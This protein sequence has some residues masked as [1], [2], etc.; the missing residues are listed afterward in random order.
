MN[1]PLKYVLLSVAGLLLLVVAGLAYIAITFDP[2]HYKTQIV[3][4]V[5]E[6]QQRI[7]RLD[8]DI[9]LIFFP[10]IGIEL[11][12]LSLSEF[13][14]D[15]PFAALNSARASLALLPLFSKR[16]VVD[17]VEIDGLQAEL[18]KFKNGTSNID[19][20]IG[21][22]SEEKKN[23]PQTAPIKFDIAA[24]NI[25]N[26]S[27]NYRN[28]ASG[29][30]YAL[31]DFNLRSGRIASGVPVKIDLVTRI[32]ANQPKLDINTQIKTIF[33][34]DLESQQ[35]AVE[36]LDMQ[37][38]GAA[39]DI[40]DLALQASG[41]AAAKL[42]TQEYAANKFNVTATGSK[43]KDRFDIK[44]TAPTLNLGKDKFNGEK[45]VFSAKLDGEVG[46]VLASLNIPGVEGNAR[47]F[48]TGVL[49]LDMDVKQPEQAFKI[50]LSTPLFG[51]FEVPQFN[52][53]DIV[54]AVH[55][56]GD[57]LPN[58][59]VK[60]EMRGS[61][62]VDMERESMQLTLAGG[63][64]Q[65]QVK[66]KLGVNNFSK[67]MTRFDVDVDQLD[68]DLYLPKRPA[69]AVSAKPATAG[70]E[71][72]LD[73]SALKKLNLEGSL[74]IGSLK[75]ANVKVSQLR[76]DMKAQ[77][78]LLN[79]SPLSAKLYQ[80]SLNGS[81]T[82]NAAHSIP[83]FTI[84]QNLSGID[85]GPLLKDAANIDMLQGKGNVTLNLTTQGNLVG[86]LKKGLNGGMSLSLSDGAVKGINIAKKLR[87]FGKG[88][89][90]QAADNSEKTDFSEMK[91][92]FKVN[93]G[94]AHNDD[95]LLKSPLIRLGGVGDINIGN[96]SINYLAK[97]TL[98][99]TLEGQG[100]KDMVG[101]ITVPVR[102]SG[103][104]T[105]LKYTIEFGALVSEVAKQKVEAKKEE[106]KKEEVKSKLQ[107]Q[108]KSGLKDLFK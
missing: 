23:E 11:E 65:S 61:A 47:S 37:V 42:G 43:G 62:Q 87:E 82:V 88:T 98:A 100:G 92:S 53:S 16:L 9:K 55:A 75:A 94:V 52:L 59:S 85:V 40:T 67:P 93:N 99:K 19:D 89:Q 41:D 72:P 76:A 71:Q 21:K 3:E 101:G 27:L 102:L 36:G 25:T 5:K 104:Y 81:L 86:G 84:N 49:I 68:A 13:Q 66:A 70:P 83:T 77:N 57:K 91:A 69:G 73:L 63:L 14:S 33:T 60:S 28:E 12:K 31:K 96:D 2:N 34:F 1:K 4:A 39:L 64:L 107:E 30:H 90:T 10:S 95:L 48:K 17:A 45:L 26:S 20:L 7:L 44:F 18:V 105:D 29:T 38:K 79:I 103:P 50:K 56:T 54:L 6:K 58:K 35:Y 78:G 46:Q 8:G 108:L 24:V 51:N 80:G 22:G 106:V 74:R 15:K 97:A 32:E